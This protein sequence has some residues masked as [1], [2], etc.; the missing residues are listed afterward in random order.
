MGSGD[1]EPPGSKDMEM[2]MWLRL[3]RVPWGIRNTENGL[4]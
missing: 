4:E 3:K 1:N 2:G